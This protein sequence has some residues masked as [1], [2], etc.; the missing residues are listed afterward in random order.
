MHEYVE[1]DLLGEELPPVTPNMERAVAAWQAWKEKEGLIEVVA[2]EQPVYHPDGYAGTIDAVIRVQDGGLR[3][4][5]W[6]TSS[7]HYDKTSLQIAAY[8]RVWEYV[9]AQSVKSGLVIRFDKKQA[10]LTQARGS[11]SRVADSC[12]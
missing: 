6:K 5:D 3:V 2:I 11:V 1:K 12:S 4:L 8:A 7:R 9:T 10:S